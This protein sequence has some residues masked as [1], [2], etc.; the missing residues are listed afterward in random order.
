MPM[1][2][3]PAATGYFVGNPTLKPT[4][5]DSYYF[6]ARVALIQDE[7]DENGTLIENEPY[8]TNLDMFGESARRAHEK[9]RSGDVF[10]AVG[11]PEEKTLT[12][13]D[14]EPFVRERF[15]ASHIGH[16]NNVTNYSVERRSAERDTAGREAPG[17]NT[18]QADAIQGASASTE[19]TGTE[20][21]ST[22]AVSAE[23]AGVET[24]GTEAVGTGTMGA[25]ATGTEV[26]GTEAAGPEAV[27][28]EA[29]SAET[30]GTEVAGTEAAG[31]EAT[32]VENVPEQTG[33]VP[34]RSEPAQDPVAEVLAERE[35]QLETESATTP[36]TA[37]AAREP[38]AR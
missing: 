21:A 3:E 33:E 6:T 8:Y 24:A 17:R 38:V 13:R 22:E 4:R 14:G 7:I 11:K 26:A 25:E 34:E 2:T 10:L 30:P 16:D 12:N 31:M 32:A 19:A 23:T 28:T 15:R 29:A 36:T 1:P 27:E 20:A 35:A 18:V 5:N 9:F 37:T